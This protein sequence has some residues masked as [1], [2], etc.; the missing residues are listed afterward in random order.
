MNRVKC[1]LVDESSGVQKRYVVPISSKLPSMKEFAR[2][3]VRQY[4]SAGSVVSG[5]CT[6]RVARESVRLLGWIQDPPF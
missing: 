4:G 2:F 1:T 5:L 6:S 3:A